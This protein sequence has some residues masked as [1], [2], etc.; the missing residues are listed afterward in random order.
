MHSSEFRVKTDRKN[1]VGSLES[2]GFSVCNKDK[3]EKKRSFLMSDLP[4]K[5]SAAINLSC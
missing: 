4:S 5:W 3:T 1:L 2:A